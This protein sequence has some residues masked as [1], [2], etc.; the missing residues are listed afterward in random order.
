MKHSAVLIVVLVLSAV[1]SC[2]IQ[3]AKGTRETK[4]KIMATSPEFFQDPRK[5]L[6]EKYRREFAE[7]N[8]NNSKKQTH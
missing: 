2:W 7:Y 8:Y 3:A 5:I 6:R 4:K 1:G